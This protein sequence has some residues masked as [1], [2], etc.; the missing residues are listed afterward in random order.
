MKTLNR[1]QL[2]FIAICAMLCDHIAWGFVDFMTPLGQVMHVIGRLTIPIMCFF[3]A[4]GYRHTSSVKGYIRRMV[5]FWIVAVI[6]FYLF[7][8]EMYG[9]RQNIIF[10]LLLGLLML[11]VLENKK[12]KIWQ[13]AVLGACIFGV[14]IGVGGWI[15]MPIL[16]ILVFY[17]VRDF[18]KQAVWVCG[19]TV[20]LELFLIAAMA[21]NHIWHFSHYDWPW[22]DKLYFLG[23]M[24]PLF[25]LKRYNGEKGK[26]II[27]KY[28]FYFFY[29][30]HFLVLTGIKVLIGGVSAYE[31]YVGAHVLAL[32]VS[33]CIL[34][35]VL[36]AKPSRGQTATLL[37][38]LSA[39][40]YT[41]GFLVEI[42]SGNVG[43]FYA[44][45]VVEYFGECLVLIAFTMFVGEMCHREVPP[46]VYA[47]EVV[48][49]LF[50][51][52]LLFTT[53]E[54]H[55]FY[56]SIGIS[57]DGPFPRQVLDRG[58]GFTV[59]LI[60]II[61]ICLGC[62]ITCIL[63]ILRSKGAERR[64]ITCTAVSIICPWLPNFLRDAGL[65][66]G[67]EIPCFG[68]VLAVV[69]VGMALIRYGYFDSIALAGENALN[70]G[71]EGIM[72]IDSR[73]IITYCNKRM[74]QMFAE[75]APK[76]DAYENPVLKDIFEG[77]IKTLE[78]DDKIY[79]MR[80]EPLEEG[81]YIQAYMLWILDITEHHKLLLQ[82]SDLAH[83]DSL[84]GIYNR[85]YFMSLLEEY[86]K[87]GGT[88]SLFMM[89]LNHFKQ[90]NDRLGHQV[91]DAVLAKFGTV[92]SECGTDTFA[93]RIGGDEF[94]LFY[95]E[96]VDTKEIEA[97]VVRINDRFEQTMQGEKYAGMTH[98]AYG[99]AR[100][101]ETSDRD[102]EKL[103]SD[104]DKALYVAKHRNKNKWYVL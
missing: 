26:N 43:G 10:D 75:I 37:F 11:A 72:V 57:E 94:C 104:A 3:I 18:K 1:T 41:F 58:W 103:Y 2:K 99:V 76:K 59:F 83:K 88:G 66:G 61:A 33:L 78:Q 9:Y 95:Q 47:A 91:G 13:K 93:C 55:Y 40:I 42:T 36:R 5:F 70:H 90:V 98:V 14:S 62:F 52:W 56:T 65:T 53:R 34:L 15:I 97:M 92:L 71:Q 24:L 79:E 28:F 19:L 68:I 8:G 60:Y 77:K 67:Y 38:V 48:S 63:G 4:E 17:Y 12:F 39:C 84:T 89:D 50:I 86:L 69:L 29:P 85:T 82:I 6:P 27:G 21:L 23:F 87:K 81:G 22:Y 16:Y 25:L 96:T 46:F 45:T 100:I 7:F 30:A 20:A 64:R 80:I 31:L 101:L 44:A 73:H 35:I 74:E 54:N 32:L 49:G 102:F 51:M